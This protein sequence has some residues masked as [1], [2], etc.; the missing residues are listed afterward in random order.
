MSMKLSAKPYDFEFDFGTTAILA[1]DFQKDFLESDGFG[2]EEGGAAF[3]PKSTQ[4]VLENVRQIFDAARKCGLQIIH[5]RSG[6]YPDL[7][8]LPYHKVERQKRAPG[9]EKRAVIGD[10]GPKGRMLI[11]GEENQDL[12]DLLK[13]HPGELVIDKPGTGAFGGTGLDGYLHDRQ[14]TSLIIVGCTTECC[15]FSTLREA[16]D[17]GYDC[18]VLSNCVTGFLPES[19]NE[20]CVNLI[21]FS[22]GLFGFVSEDNHGLVRQLETI[23][24]QQIS[25][26]LPKSLHLDIPALLTAYRHGLVQPIDVVRSCYER[27]Q[28][29][30]Q[31]DQTVFLHLL[32]WSTVS[33]SVN[34]LTQQYA[35]HSGLPPL[36]GVPFVIKDN[37]DIAGVPSTAACPTLGYIPQETATCVKR[38]QAA[39]AILL[40]K[41]NMD[42]FATGLAGMRSPYGNPS[43]VYSKD[44]VAGGSSSGSA[45]AVGHNLVSFA[46]GTD[47]AASGRVPASY[48][49]VVGWKPTRGSSSIHGVI[50]ASPSLDC[51][52]ILARDVR[53][54]WEAWMAIRGHDPLDL[55]SETQADGPRLAN[56]FGGR[57]VGKSMQGRPFTFAVPS[58]EVLSLLNPHHRPAFERAIE[59]LERLG[60]KRS[61]NFNWRPFELA[62]KDLYGSARIAERAACL[63]NFFLKKG[64]D[65]DPEQMH[66]VTRQAVRDLK[67]NYS[68]VDAFESMA[69]LRQFN[70][71]ARKSWKFDISGKPYDTPVD[72]ILTPTVPFHPTKAEV[73]KEPLA[74]N[75]KLGL[76][77]QAVNLLDMSALAIP[78]EELDDPNFTSG[79]APFGVQLIADKWEDGFLLTLG[80]KLMNRNI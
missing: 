64:I 79:K 47:T 10:Q 17:R 74:V 46:L 40:G 60:G 65:F 72:V 11:R 48:N 29:Y 69:A 70:D 37:M 22:N 8:D 25:K 63:R 71:D 27:V 62:Q 78:F 57:F 26:T 9:A 34:R 20:A 7:S 36:F 44:H 14:I 35:R 43:S 80:E 73:E 66:P 55:Y 68:A 67:P 76:Y 13:A 15:V 45:V 2:A 53:S 56:R 59:A 41:T 49:G 50:P 30:H 5:T 31:Q 39:G 54:A 24:Q 33:A 4:P 21:S 23:A 32:E 6:H 51:V 42:Q 58:E 1:V 3:N 16:N 75:S 77:S 38:L 19:E 28:S 52:S 61:N 18:C 12:V